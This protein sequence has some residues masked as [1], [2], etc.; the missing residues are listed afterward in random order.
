MKEIST[1]E[2]AHKIDNRE[3][4][5]LIDVREEEE[6]AGGM[7]PGSKHIPLGDIPN[8]LD[9]FDSSQEYVI[10]CRSGG[11]SGKAQEFLLSNGINAVNMAGGMLDWNGKTEKK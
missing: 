9:A 10:V 2:V 3:S 7:I 6:V 8:S 4:L 11:R 1:K 5:N